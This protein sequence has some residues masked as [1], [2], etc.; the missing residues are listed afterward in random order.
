MIQVV[1]KGPLL[2]ILKQ[3]A[4]Q[5]DAAGN[6]RSPFFHN[7]AQAPLLIMAVDH[8]VSEVEKEALFRFEHNNRS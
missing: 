6:D 8:S 4:D 7:R 5:T 1:V 3:D 2:T